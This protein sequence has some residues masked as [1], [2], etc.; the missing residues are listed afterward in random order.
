MLRRFLAT[1]LI[2]LHLWSLAA[3]ADVRVRVLRQAGTTSTGNQDFTVAGVGTPKGFLLVVTNAITDG[4]AA[5]SAVF[6]VSAGDCSAYWTVHK[7]DVDALTTTATRKRAT[8]ASAPQMFT[9]TTGSLGWEGTPSCIPDGIRLNITTALPAAWLVHVVLFGGTDVSAKAGTFASNAT[10]DGTT[11]VSDV[12]FLPQDIVVTST[13]LSTFNNTSSSGANVGIGIANAT[14]QG[15]TAQGVA[16]AVTTTS[17]TAGVHSAWAGVVIA[18]GDF[19]GVSVLLG[20]FTGTGFVATTKEANSSVSFGYL[21]L[22]YNGKVRSWNGQVNAPAGT[23]VASY[24]GPGWT[25][26]FAL[27]LPTGVA[28]AN[29][30]SNDVDNATID[31]NAGVHGVS[32]LD[33]T[34]Q[35]SVSLSGDDAATTSDAKAM[36]TAQAVKVMDA[37]GATRWLATLSGFTAT[38]FDLDFTTTSGTA[39]WRGW[40]IERSK[41]VGGGVL[42]T[43]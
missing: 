32:L 5:D 10:I 21:A 2:A 7:Q 14:S 18:N 12:G 42:T 30:V 41:P 13:G 40:A 6:S 1:T 38:G 4:T 23:G 26:Q 24:T 43:E 27:L 35:Y 11:T 31:D 9:A 39:A 16:N 3:F 19:P 25:P 15:A 17:Y 29:V 36:S 8:T 34:K 20:T 37:T 33:Q 28:T 22:S